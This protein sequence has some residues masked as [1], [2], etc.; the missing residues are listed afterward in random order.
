MSA[1]IA[2]SSI[3]QVSSGMLPTVYMVAVLPS[4]LLFARTERT[5]KEDI[6]EVCWTSYPLACEEVLVVPPVPGPLFIVG[7]QCLMDG[8]SMCHIYSSSSSSSALS[9][10]LSAPANHIYFNHRFTQWYFFGFGA[11]LF[12]LICLFLSPPLPA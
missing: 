11:S 12:L 10:T 6:V 9:H 2:R 1:A 5:H 4:H 3:L 8:P 7:T